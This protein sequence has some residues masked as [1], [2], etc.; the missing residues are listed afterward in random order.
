MEKNKL[1]KCGVFLIGGSAGSIEV[2]LEV[3][4]TLDFA[5]SFPIVV[6]LHRG[7]ASDSVLTELLSFKSSLP[8][9]E[10]EDKDAIKPGVIYMAPPDYHLL[11]EK[12]KTF[13]LDISEKINY[14][15]PSI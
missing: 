13:S 2:V 1:T 15:R 3:L 8:I 6:I 5:I 12:N 4:R 10:V 7:S 9:R 11:F 14:S